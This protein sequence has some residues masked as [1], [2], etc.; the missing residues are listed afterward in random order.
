MDIT[1]K[2]A[3]RQNYYAKLLDGNVLPS[4]TVRLKHQKQVSKLPGYEEGDWWVQDFS[5]SLPIKLLG[6][7]DGFS[8]LDVCA[9]PG[10]KTLQLISGG[11][12]VTAIEISEKRAKILKENMNRT[13]LVA[14][15]I[16]GDLQQ[17][18]TNK[19]FDI[20]LVDAPCSATG[21]LRRNCE[22]QYLDPVSRI[23]G[24]VKQQKA[25]LKKSMSFVKLG[26]ILVYC[27][28]SLV[29]AE[30]E[31]IISHVL[32]GESSWKQVLIKSE[33][34]G[35]NEAWLDVYGGLRLRPDYWPSIGGMDG[36]YI[37]ILTREN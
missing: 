35:I 12:S 5:A 14:E 18:K 31:D 8:A 9:A 21:T 2:D 23:N 28:C 32:D 3:T 27:T 4:G 22:L 7:I 25:I 24:L 20:V 29:P 16:I 1:L 13:S 10:S 37:A 36:F 33:N 15:L 6:A 17:Y 26:G 19:L 30:G 11:A 34:L